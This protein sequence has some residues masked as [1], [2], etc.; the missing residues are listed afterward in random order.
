[1][2]AQIIVA[3]LIVAVAVLVAADLARTKNEPDGSGY[4]VRPRTIGETHGHR[5]GAS[6]L[7]SF[8]TGTPA[9]GHDASLGGRPGL[10]G[11]SAADPQP[12]RSGS[13]TARNSSAMRDK[14]SLEQGRR[15]VRSRLQLLVIIPA[16]AVAIIAACIAGLAYSLSGARINSPSSS[17]RD[18]AIVW[19]IVSGVLMIV[20]AVLAVRATIGTTRSV[21]QPLY[22]VRSRALALAAGRPSDVAPADTASPDEIGDIARAVEQLGSR[23]SRLGGDEAGLRSK[24]DAMFVNVSHRG[25]SLV[26]RQMRLIDS[27][28]QGEHDRGRRATL[29]RMNRIAAR[30]HRDS[31]NLLV[32]AGHDLSSSWNQPMVLTNIIRAAVAEVEEFERIAVQTQPDIAVSAPAVNDMV[33]LL[34]ELIQNATSFSAVDMPVEI[35]GQLLNTGGALI[36]ITDRGVGMSAQEMAH[37]NWRLE[38]APTGDL[39]VPKWVGLL[40]VA[41]LAARH[42][43]RVR[44]QQAEFGGLT[45]LVWVPDQLLIARQDAAA[46]PQFTRSGPGGLRRGAHEIAVDQRSAVAQPAMPAARAGQVAASRE[47]VRGTLPDRRPISGENPLPDPVPAAVS[48]P[49][50]PQADPLMART[51]GSGTGQLVSAPQ[52]T[53]AALQQETGSADSSVVVPPTADPA[54]ERRLPIFEAVES[55][56][57]KGGRRTPGTARTAVTAGSHWSSPADDGWRAAQTVESPAAGS[58]TEA[59]LPRRLPNANLLPGTIPGAQPAAAPVRSAADIRDRLSGFQRGVTKGRAA[60]SE[61]AKPAGD[62]ES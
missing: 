53:T 6:S 11:P 3:I 17:V 2:L 27:L 16:A 32:L 5:T 46:L 57:F 41:R 36:S 23:I 47:E 55:S 56:W 12:A 43:V 58:P 49:P 24:L 18:Q 8:G 35:S 31:Q 51:G 40:V 37:A 44:L 19:A 33:H 20:V 48:S 25:Q 34:A 1:M 15:H 14:V 42:G 28:E 9:A 62:D 21:L 60:A 54:E 13:P 45:A 10:A 30:M 39:E 50:V 22:R 52:V 61:A 4:E 7:E 29:F 59:G 26:E 38:N